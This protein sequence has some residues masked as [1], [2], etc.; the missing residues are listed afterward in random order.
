VILG[1]G[2]AG[3]RLAKKLAKKDFDVTL[4][5][6]NN[7]HQF[8]PL[9]YQVATAGLAP[10]SISFPVRKV[11]HKADNVRFRL[12]EVEELKLDSNSVKTSIG[13]FEFDYL[14]IATG[15]DTNYF[16]NEEI[17]RNSF[18][19]K[20]VQ[21]SL[22]LRNRILEC[23]EDA[24]IAPTEAEREALMNIVV[25]GGGPTGTEVSG[26]LAEMRDYV[27]PLDYPELDFNR[28]GIHLLE[29]SPRL[30]G[31]MSDKASEN[32]LRSLEDMGVQVH[33]SSIVER[34][35]GE[36]VIVKG[37]E[38]I[39][40][41]TLIWAAGVKGNVLPGLP[42]DKIIANARVKVDEVNRMQDSDSVFVIGDLAYMEEGKF[43]RG[44]PQVAQVAIQQ[45]DKLAKNLIAINR[46]NSPSAFHYNDLRSMA[47]I[48]RNRAV[49]DLPWIKFHGFPAWMFWLFVH[50]MAVLGVKNRL[51]IFIE[52]MWRYFTYDQSLR[53]LIK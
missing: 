20:S 27:L 17:Q 25:V 32:S 4:I 48:G 12:A 41:K 23:M 30:L 18:P 8:Q 52:W 26:A 42:Q 34:Y 46:G 45:A 51:F 28:M 35:D 47:T 39:R 13:A 9:F 31:G 22:Q 21:E 15:A 2:F 33:L 6:R 10:S 40:S 5:D 1:A 16:N 53:I 37:G 49:V 43:E 44:H 29:G 38:E 11:L 36:R 14:V 3:L 7:F 19:M 50:L 24:L